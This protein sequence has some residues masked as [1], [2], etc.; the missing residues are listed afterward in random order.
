MLPLL[1]PMTNYLLKSATISK[2][3]VDICIQTKIWTLDV[4]DV[5]RLTLHIPGTQVIWRR[6]CLE[7]CSHQYL[8]KSSL[9][10]IRVQ[11]YTQGPLNSRWE[12]VLSGHLASEATT[13]GYLSGFWL[14]SSLTLCYITPGRYLQNFKVK[15]LHQFWVNIVNK[16]THLAF[17]YIDLE[18]KV[19]VEYDLNHKQDAITM[20]WSSDCT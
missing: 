4:C 15:Y 17:E 2:H 11:K 5:S 13:S 10:R 16:C 1:R 18:K 3:L 8:Y 6:G 20:N 19:A 9:I 12:I 14:T 7:I